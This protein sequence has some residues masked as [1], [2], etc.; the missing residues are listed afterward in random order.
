MA[1]PNPPANTPPARRKTMRAV[2]FARHATVRIGIVGTGLRGRSVLNE[3]LGVD[4]VKI[5]ALCDTV[6]AKTTRASKMCTDKGHDAPAVYTEGE[7]A[8]E[9]LVARNDIDIVY[10]A[11]PWEFH[12]PVMLAALAHGKHCASECP[13]GTTL[14]C[15][16]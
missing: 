8:F 3:L 15:N 10:T 9:K 1:D 11:T 14:R 2:P 16:D 5:V 7:N 13:I 6:A 12:V 4:G